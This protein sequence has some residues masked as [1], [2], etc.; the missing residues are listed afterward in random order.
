MSDNFKARLVSI[1]LRLISITLRYRFEDPFGNHEKI[2]KSK[3]IFAFWHDRIVMMPLLVSKYL[4][5]NSVTVLQS[6]SKDGRIASQVVKL[7]GQHTIVGSSYDGGAK[8][9]KE[10]I[11]SV[12]ESHRHIAFAPDGPRGP[13]Y[14]IQQGI[15]RLAR[16]SCL[17]IVPVNWTCSRQWTLNNWDKTMIPKPFSTCVVRVG[18]FVSIPSNASKDELKTYSD[19]LHKGLMKSGELRISKQ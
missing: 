7:F 12:V 6:P 2:R 15:L 3:V 10:L 5:K 4:S 11:R 13:R 16:K 8:A 17:P 19:T 18:E 14:S 1:V 9:Y